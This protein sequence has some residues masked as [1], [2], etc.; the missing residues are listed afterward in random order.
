MQMQY[1]KRDLN[2]NKR[3]HKGKVKSRSK[4]KKIPRE[5]ALLK[6]KVTFN[7]IIRVHTFDKTQKTTKPINKIMEN[8]KENVFLFFCKDLKTKKFQKGKESI[9]SKLLESRFPLHQNPQVLVN[10]CIS[11]AN[12]SSRGG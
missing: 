12:G 11:R 8:N 3:D 7:L 6:E 10:R 1:S 2:A 5:R 4:E 9:I